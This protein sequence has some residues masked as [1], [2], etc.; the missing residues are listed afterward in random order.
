MDDKYEIPV[1][2]YLVPAN[3]SAKFEFFE[4]FGWYEFKIVLMTALVGLA[5]YFMLGI[6]QKTIYIDANNIPPAMLIGASEEELTPNEDGYIVKYE[7]S[8]PGIVRLLFII[9]PSVAAFYLVKRDPTSGLCAISTLKHLKAFK[10]KQKLYLYKYNSG[11][12]YGG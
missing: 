5:F 4:G 2:H 8:V 1:T 10:N 6:F 7:D 11:T 3:V 12:G 9:I